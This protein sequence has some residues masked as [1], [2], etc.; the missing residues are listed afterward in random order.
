MKIEETD[1]QKIKRLVKKAKWNPLFQF[2]VASKRGGNA[3]GIG[4]KRSVILSSNGQGNWHQFVK[5]W[6]D[7]NEKRAHFIVNTAKE[8][9]RL[10]NTKS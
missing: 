5:V 2:F 8:Q 4:E 1:E 3:I 6:G 9:I 7:D 10:T